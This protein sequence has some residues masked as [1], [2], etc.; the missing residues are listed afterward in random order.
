MRRRAHAQTHAGTAEQAA[1]PER[2]GDEEEEEGD[3][4]GMKKKKK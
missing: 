3:D 4:E 1:R 2:N